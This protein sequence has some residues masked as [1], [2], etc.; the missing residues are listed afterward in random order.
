MEYVFA[1]LGLAV[2]VALYM[3]SYTLNEKCEKP[4]G[5]EEQEC[6]SCHSRSCSTRKHEVK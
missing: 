2:L 4:E 3:W 6:K 1:G 5:A